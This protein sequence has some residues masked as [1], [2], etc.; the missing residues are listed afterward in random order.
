MLP[1][2]PRGTGDIPITGRISI[3]TTPIGAIIDMA[4]VMTSGSMRNTI[5]AM[6]RGGIKDSVTA[7]R[8]HLPPGKGDRAPVT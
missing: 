3:E 4:I 8:R 2:G 7:A 6:A 1:G 5:M